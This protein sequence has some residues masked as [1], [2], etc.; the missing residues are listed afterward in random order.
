MLSLGGRSPGVMTVRH[1]LALRPPGANTWVPGPTVETRRA[2]PGAPR[3]RAVGRHRGAI[4]RARRGR[5]EAKAP[6]VRLG[7]GCARERDRPD[8]VMAYLV[9]PSASPWADALDA[10]LRGRPP[11]G[12]ARVDGLG[13]C[14]TGRA[15]L[16]DDRRGTR[17]PL[18]TH[19][20][21]SQRERVPRGGR[22]V[23]GLQ[24]LGKE[25]ANG[26]ARVLLGRA[27]QG[28]QR[29]LPRSAGD[30]AV[31]TP[32]GDCRGDERKRR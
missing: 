9:V 8:H 27:D 12:H 30:V 4:V 25:L 15:E 29:S 11:F 18:R 32:V 22:R 21:P 13:A 26:A 24:R 6:Y 2:A 5:P 10:P 14:L 19:C 23:G 28:G 20:E 1:D 7:S 31:S 16:F 17:I 3:R